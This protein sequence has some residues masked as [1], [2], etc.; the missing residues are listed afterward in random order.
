MLHAATGGRFDPTIQPLWALYAEHFAGARRRDLPPAGARAAALARTGWQRVRFDGARIRL[1]PG[2]ALSLNGIAQGY[3]ADRLADLLRGMGLD[4]PGT[5]RVVIIGGGVV[6]VGAVSSGPAGWTDCLLLEKQRA[7][8]RVH[9]ARGGE[10][11]DVFVLVV[12]HEHA[13]LFGRALPGAGRGGRLSDELP[14]H[15]DR[16]GWAIPRSGCA[17]SP[18]G[19][20]GAVSGDGPGHPRPVRDPDEIP[21]VE[22]HDLTGAL[23]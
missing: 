23:L 16:C 14:R 5:A 20:D 8:R 4:L 18:R 1:E 22:T 7:D 19:G 6:G 10:R 11:A 3:I 12:D 21:F 15:R 9:L 2:M 17:S 13:A